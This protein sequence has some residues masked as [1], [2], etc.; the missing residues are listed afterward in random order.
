MRKSRSV[1]HWH[2]IARILAFT[3]ANLTDYDLVADPIWK[4]LEVLDWA[5]VFVRTFDF[6]RSL[7]RGSGLMRNIALSDNDYLIINILFVSS[8]F[9]SRVLLSCC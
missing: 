1:I 5:Q 2:R 3:H 6:T 8:S 4:L 7:S 9:L